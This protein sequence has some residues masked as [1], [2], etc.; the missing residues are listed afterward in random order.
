[1][2]DWH[3]KTIGLTPDMK[4]LTPGDRVQLGF[5]NGT[6]DVVREHLWVRVSQVLWGGKVYCGVTETDAASIEGLEAGQPLQFKPEHVA[7]VKRS[8]QDDIH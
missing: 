6:S 3:L 4:R 2:A 7:R 5:C 8:Y 1:M